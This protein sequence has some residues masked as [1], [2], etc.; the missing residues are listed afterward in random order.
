MGAT[1]RTG[2]LTSPLRDR[3]GVTARLEFYPP[4]D[5]QQI[6][7]RSAAKLSVPMDAEGAFEIARRARGT[8]RIANRLLRRVRDFAQVRAAGSIDLPVASEA[9]ALLDVDERGFDHM[10]RTILRTIVEKFAGGPVGV[11]TI[12][13]AINEERD[14]IE[15][16]YEP[17]LIQC[18]LIHRTPRG[19]VATKLAY[20][21]LGLHAPAAVQPGLFD[22]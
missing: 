13:S 10:D 22:E 16:V 20:D 2:L 8:P 11:E 21:H 15:D 9:L 6:V 5:L 18:G 12:A 1:T 4:E 7:R 3:F 19:R 17:Y 14:T